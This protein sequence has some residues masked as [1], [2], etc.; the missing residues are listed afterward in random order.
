MAGPKPH[1]SAAPRVPDDPVARAAEQ[2]PIDDEPV[3]PKE[4]AAVEKARREVRK[5]RVVSHD[6]V[7]RR[8][9]KRS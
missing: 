3:T 1:G 8:W 9:T 6:D 7:R 5:G 4:E 2:A